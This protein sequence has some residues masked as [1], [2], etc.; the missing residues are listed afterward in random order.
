MEKILKLQIV[1]IYLERQLS[2]YIHSP[3]LH[4]HGH[5]LHSTH[6][7]LL[8]GAQEV[9][10]VPE[11]A[12]RSPDTEPD[13]VGHVFGFAGAGGTGVYDT[14][15]GQRVLELQYGLSGFCRFTSP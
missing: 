1:V 12:A 9:V 10:E 5:D 8:H 11:G 7:P 2:G 3:E 14:G 4:I 6:A 13:H 15:F